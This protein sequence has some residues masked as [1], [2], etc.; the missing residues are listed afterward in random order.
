MSTAWPRRESAGGGGGASARVTLSWF[1]ATVSRR[2]MPSREALAGAVCDVS[3]GRVSAGRG[4]GGVP[5]TLSL[6]LDAIEA[7]PITEFLF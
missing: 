7:L 3:A 1:A 6:M 2:V 4:V 5:G